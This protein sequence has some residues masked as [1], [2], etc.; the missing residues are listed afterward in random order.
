M[1]NKKNRLGEP[2]FVERAN[3][4]FY[5]AA[6]DRELIEEMKG[7]AQN[8]EAALREERAMTCPKCAGKL[9]SYRFMQFV[10]DRCQSCEGIW[11]EK[12]E[13]ETILRR[14]TLGPVGAFLE[15]CFPKIRRMKSWT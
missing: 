10:L 1:E 8:A 14:A 3:E 12:G 11:L 5:F 7:Q 2:E 4:D 13:L 6:K 9:Q 15:R